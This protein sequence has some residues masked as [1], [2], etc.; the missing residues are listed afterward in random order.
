M[1]ATRL[2]ALLLDNDQ[3]VSDFVLSSGVAPTYYGKLYLRSRRQGSWRW[4]KRGVGSWV[5]WPV[6]MGQALPHILRGAV[7][8]VDRTE[9]AL[10]VGPKSSNQI[11]NVSF[12]RACAMAG[13][14][15]REVK[16]A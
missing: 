14:D 10:G 4:Q 2:C 5:F 1:N 11:L 7:I 13:L 3:E 15:P 6:Y 12:E 16:L 9:G 8:E